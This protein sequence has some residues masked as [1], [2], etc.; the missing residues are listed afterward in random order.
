LA[1][2][3]DQT[4]IE[5]LVAEIEA[6]GGSAT[7]FMLNVVEEGSIEQLVENVEEDIGPIV[8]RRGV[9]TP[10]GTLSH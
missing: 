6:E 8:N 3:S 2:R 4:G 1:R 7:S 10:V 5:R 9:P